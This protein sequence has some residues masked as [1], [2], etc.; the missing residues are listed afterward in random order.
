MDPRE[1]R[2]ALLTRRSLFGRSAFGLGALALGSLIGGEAGAAPGRPAAP[3]SP[4]PAL[5][6]FAPKARRVIYLLQNGAPSH[7]DLF[8]YKPTLK[9]A[10]G[11][12]IPP[13]VQGGQRL[14]TMTSGQKSKPV[15]PNITTFGRHG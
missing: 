8:D 10:M 6:H 13:S 1:E 11:Q 2:K 4:R 14:S 3:G 15:L 9:E 12:E 7:V 5:P